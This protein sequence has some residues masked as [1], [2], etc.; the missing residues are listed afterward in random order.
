MFKQVDWTALKACIITLQK[1]KCAMCKKYLED[2]EFT[3]HHIVPRDKGGKDELDNLIGLCDK[4]H[5]IAED[6]QLNRKEIINY[7]DYGHIENIIKK[8]I[9][10][11]FEEPTKY[12][13][14]EEII[15]QEKYIIPLINERPLRYVLKYG[16]SIKEIAKIFGVCNATVTKWDKDKEKSLWLKNK[17]EELKEDK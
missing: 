14:P 11:I 13:F 12:K 6:K 2:S 16:K 7:E 5:D 4:C 9:M 3:L 10:P 8:F 1:N 17:L 15:L